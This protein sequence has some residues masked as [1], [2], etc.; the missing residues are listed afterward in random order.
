MMKDEKLNRL[1]DSSWKEYFNKNKS[2]YEVKKV[3]K[4]K[5]NNNAP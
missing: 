2:E 5:L 3:S 1:P 4:N